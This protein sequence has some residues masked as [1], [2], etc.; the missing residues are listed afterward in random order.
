MQVRFVPICAA[1]TLFFQYVSV[2]TSAVQFV[3][4]LVGSTYCTAVGIVHV[5]TVGTAGTVIGTVGMYIQQ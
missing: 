5:R 3:R 1:A 4:V 2:P